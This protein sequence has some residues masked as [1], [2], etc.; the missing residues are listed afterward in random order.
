M[1]GQDA[2]RKRQAVIDAARRMT[3]VIEDLPNTPDEEKA[4]LKKDLHSIG[5]NALSSA[6]HDFCDACGKLTVVTDVWINRLPVTLCQPCI[7]DAL[8]AEGE[9]L[10]RYWEIES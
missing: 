5:V 8:T 3:K 2:A 10:G 6:D 7:L 1:T 9:S 4:T